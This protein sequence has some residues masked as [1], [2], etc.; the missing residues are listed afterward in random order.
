MRTL[1]S[2]ER[3]ARRAAAHHLHPVVT[4]GHHG[5]TPA[6]L[7]EIDVALNAHELVKIRVFSD[8]REE[9]AALLARICDGLDA[10]AVQHLGKILTVWRPAPEPELPVAKPRKT[11]SKDTGKRRRPNSQGDTRR[12]RTESGAPRT[13]SPPAAP[14]GPSARHRNPAPRGDSRADAKP[15]ARRGP[16]SATGHEPTRR[17]PRVAGSGKSA[18]RG[19]VATGGGKPRS[20]VP[21]TRRRR[22]P[23]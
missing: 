1:T 13:K 12:S 17:P 20:A 19:P 16:A 4:I 14:G 2:A 9:R 15:F 6:V 11:P 3:R 10:A 21:G 23:R 22:T 18:K 8:D 7:H 5:L